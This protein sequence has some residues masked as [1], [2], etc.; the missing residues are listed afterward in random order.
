MSRDGAL[1]L[2]TGNPVPPPQS[3]GLS[4]APPADAAPAKL[5]SE[6]FASQARREA[7]LVKRQ[8]LYKQEREA[9]ERERDSFKP[10][11]EKFKQFE[12]LQKTDKIAAMKA[13]GFSE[14][15][16]I[17]YLAEE[18]TA[19]KT[20]EE[21]AIAAAEAA[22]DARFKAYE[23]QQAKKAKDDQ[24]V[25]DKK[26][27]SD[28]NA[29]LTQT[30]ESNKDKYEF[31]NFHGPA[32]EDLVRAFIVQV[33]KESEG[34]ETIDA[35]EALD[36]VEEYYEEQDQAMSGLKKRQPKDAPKPEAPK[37]SER[38]RKVTPGFP[39]EKQA[40][41]PI[42]RSRDLSNGATSNMSA[43]SKLNETRD[44]KR[45]RLMEALRMGVK[46]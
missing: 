15:D 38:S 10:I 42:S 24:A 4:E 19:E 22:A 36:L 46:P 35:K 31:C 8:Q 44:Q 21:R 25:Q 41:A 30:I 34:K 39:N 16:I 17:N 26:R 5:D 45:E 7:D 13:V 20:T 23:D 12:E 9:F 11:A 6:R 2:A 40:P 37:E 43:R 27:I 14:A 29:A 33:F 1:A 28:F 18:G 32:A 3:P